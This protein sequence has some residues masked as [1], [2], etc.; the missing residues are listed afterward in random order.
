AEEMVRWFGQPV[1]VVV[2]RDRYA[3]EDGLEAIEADYEP[4]PPIPDAESAVA[5]GAAVL[6]PELGDN[7]AAHF[8][9]GSG[10]VDAAFAN[11]P[12]TLRERFVFGRHAANAMETRGVQASYDEGRNELMVW[13]T[14]ARPHLVRTFISEMLGFPLESVHV[15]APDMGG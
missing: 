11:A 12:H 15:I 13:V 6:H 7:V 3:A 1:A 8:R 5:A 9:V 4:L 2:A 14:N 10:D